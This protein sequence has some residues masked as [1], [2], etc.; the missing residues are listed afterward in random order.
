MQKL[1]LVK[2]VTPLLILI[3]IYVFL[4]F[5]SLTGTMAYVAPISSWIVLGLITLMIYGLS[6][7]RSVFSKTLVLLAGLMAAMQILMLIF[8]SLFT[9]FGRSPYSFTP[10]ALALNVLYFTSVLFGTELARAQLIRAVPRRQKLLSVGSTA[11]LFTVISFSTARYL[12][13]SASAETFKF[14]G[15]NFLPTLAGGVL[16]TYLAL[17]GGPTA[18]IAYMG[19]LQ[20]FEWL[21][22]ILPNPGWTFEALIGALVPTVGFMIINET[23]KPFTLFYHGLITRREATRKT[24]K[25]WKSFS[26]GW[27][28]VAIIAFLLLWG[29]MGLLGFQPSVIA[30]G[31][32][33]PTLNVGDMAIIVHV[34]PTS[35]KIGDIIQYRTA[36][37]PIIHRVIDEYVAGGTIWFITKGDA[38]KAPDPSPV[39]EQ[40]VMGKEVMIIPKLGW[41]SIA[42]KDIPSKAYSLLMTSPTSLGDAY[43]WIMTEGVYLTSVLAVIALSYLLVSNRTRRGGAE[44]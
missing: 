5:M 3:V 33:V 1:E 42:L 25:T 36:Q 7:I 11:L 38:N 16:A 28:A 44:A 8:V 12:S 29:D 26:V 41:A 23:V 22:P 35:I 32:M 43:T 24:M 21:S 2:S 39:S 31:S 17:V 6:N 13:L 9:S 19:T 27:V 15:E 30:S 34:E 4:S 18:S 20:A 10:N 14:F 37:A 40:Q